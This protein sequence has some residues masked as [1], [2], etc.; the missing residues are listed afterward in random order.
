MEMK[1]DGDKHFDKYNNCFSVFYYYYG[2]MAA[3]L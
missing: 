1:A 3:A 2:K